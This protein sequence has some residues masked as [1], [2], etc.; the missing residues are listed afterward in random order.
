MAYLSRAFKTYLLREICIGLA[1]IQGGV[2]ALKTETDLVHMT[3]LFLW[4]L[5]MES[6][7]PLHLWQ[8]A[9]HDVVHLCVTTMLLPLLPFNL[10]NL[11]Q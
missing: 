10:S 2:G 5:D 1:E 6:V 3:Q 9:D 11:P 4:L 8:S 7:G